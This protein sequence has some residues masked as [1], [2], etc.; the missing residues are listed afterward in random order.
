MFDPSG[1]RQGGNLQVPVRSRKEH[2]WRESPASSQPGF[3]A[4]SDC[5]GNGGRSGSPLT[6]P[7]KPTAPADSRRCTSKDRQ[8]LSARAHTATARVRNV[9]RCGP[10][11]RMRLTAESNPIPEAG[12]SC[13][14]HSQRNHRCS[15]PEVV[16]TT[17]REKP[18]FRQAAARNSPAKTE[19]RENQTLTNWIP[20]QCQRQSLD[21]QFREYPVGNCEPNQ[22]SNWGLRLFK[23]SSLSSLLRIRGQH[24]QYERSN[25]RG[26]RK[27]PLDE[28]W[29]W[30]R[31][32]S[33]RG[34]QKTSFFVTLSAGDLTRWTWQHSRKPGDIYGLASVI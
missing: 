28:I 20:I 31:S 5:N 33:K 26:P 22:R 9:P 15:T 23:R 7:A 29:M 21:F 25:F 13:C 4:A 24:V 18:P 3:G 27:G 1:F 16:A 14:A 8:R 11:L 34:C 10:S 2:E 12:N 6:G 32:K 30:F 19:S 17:Q